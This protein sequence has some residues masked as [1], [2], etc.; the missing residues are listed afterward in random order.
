MNDDSKTKGISGIDRASRIGKLREVTEVDSV[1]GVERTGRID[2]VERTRATRANRL[3]REISAQERA[4][5]HQMIEEESE[6]LFGNSAISPA[7]KKL[8]GDAVKM[9]IDAAIPD[10]EEES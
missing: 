2:R 3:T 9:A 5:I 6:K 1:S 4:F 7:Q 8:I 10:E